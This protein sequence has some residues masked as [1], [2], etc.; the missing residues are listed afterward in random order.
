MTILL[1][2]Q[3]GELLARERSRDAYTVYVEPELVV[4]IAFNDLQDSPQYPGGLALRFARVKAYRPD[5]R[6]QEADTIDTLL[7]WRLY[8]PLLQPPPGGGSVRRT[9]PAWQPA[10]T[11]RRLRLQRRV[12]GQQ[13]GSSFML[14]PPLGALGGGSGEQYVQRLTTPASRAGSR[15]RARRRRRRAGSSRAR[16][17]HRCLRSASAGRAAPC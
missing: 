13:A 16:A 2:W 8:A 9:K 17:R 14:E 7:A 6:A 4:E 10:N 1:E 5:K 12:A 11:P 3:T 15:R